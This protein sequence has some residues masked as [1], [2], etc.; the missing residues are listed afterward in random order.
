MEW[1]G[2]WTRKE[3]VEGKYKEVMLEGEKGKRRGSLGEEGGR[4][5]MM[6]GK[7]EREG[8]YR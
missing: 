8:I 2:D 6:K 3:K 5:K 1:N 7:E 4:E